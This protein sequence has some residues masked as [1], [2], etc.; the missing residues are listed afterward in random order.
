MIDGDATG[1]EREVLEALG[2][3]D[4]VWDELFPAEQTRIMR[5]L[6]ERIDVAIDGIDIRLRTSG[7]HHGEKGTL[8]FNVRT[9][10]K[11]GERGRYPLTYVRED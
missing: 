3:L 10:G 4:E 8:P 5:L 6:V 2:R 11:G 7:I 1:R 9:R